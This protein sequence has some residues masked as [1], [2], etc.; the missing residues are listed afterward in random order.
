MNNQ[1][2]F[3]EDEIQRDLQIIRKNYVGLVETIEKLQ[4]SSV[5]LL[6]S[7]QIIVTFRF[8]HINT[9]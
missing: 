6:E 7:T 8:P 5:S 9:N 4:N 2:K 3:Q 1:N